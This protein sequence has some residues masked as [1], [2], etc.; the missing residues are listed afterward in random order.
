[1]T[2]HDDHDEKIC[3]QVD[4]GEPEDELTDDDQDKP[5][6]TADQLTITDQEPQEVMTPA[7]LK[8]GDI[9]PLREDCKDHVQLHCNAHHGCKQG[10]EELALRLKQHRDSMWE[11]IHAFHP[12]LENHVTHY[13]VENHQ[14]KIMHLDELKKLVVF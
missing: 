8:P 4:D 6:D 12:E 7:D 2:D 3:R 11:I 5:E 9:I 10:I 1:M 13:N 14:V